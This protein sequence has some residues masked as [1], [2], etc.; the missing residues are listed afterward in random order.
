MNKNDKSPIP[1]LEQRYEVA[2]DIMFRQI[3]DEGILL[4]I[5]SGTYY[6]LSET[7]IVF[8][9]ALV[10]SEPLNLVI[11]K[12]I[13]EYEVEREVILQD[14]QIFLQDLLQNKIITSPAI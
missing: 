11:E 8:W 14:L 7:S 10:D 2:E 13:N 4:H 12:M 1:N 5:S 9:Q 3:E 6:N